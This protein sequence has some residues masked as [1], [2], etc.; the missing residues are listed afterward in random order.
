MGAR[1][2]ISFFA[3]LLA[4]VGIL[5][6]GVVP[7]RY[8][9]EVPIAVDATHHVRSADDA[10]GTLRADECLALHSHDDACAAA[11]ACHDCALLGCDA[12]VEGGTGCGDTGDD[13]PGECF[14][15][16]AFLPV[17]K[18]H[19]AGPCLC[20]HVAAAIL[21]DIC[22]P[23]AASVACRGAGAKPKPPIITLDCDYLA[24]PS[25]LRA[26]PVC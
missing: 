13:G 9:R 11:T 22:K 6:H 10:R 18:R 7:H 5:A 24:R 12:P 1:R 20:C 4:N 2:V 14:V 21:P 15:E 16:R 26:P 8:H 3:L 25:G 23:A 17:E 19:G